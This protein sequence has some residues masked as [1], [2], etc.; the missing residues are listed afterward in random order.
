MPTNG[1]WDLIRRLKGGGVSVSEPRDAERQKW[2]NRP[3]DN[4]SWLF[5]W[6]VGWLVVWH[7]ADGYTLPEN[8]IFALSFVLSCRRSEDNTHADTEVIQGTRVFVVSLFT[9]VSEE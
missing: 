2:L 3:R 1:R 8:L 5:G 7:R 6:L 4:L 9:C